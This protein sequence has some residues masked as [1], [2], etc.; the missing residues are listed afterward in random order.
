M[1]F[2]KHKRTRK[3]TQHPAIDDF[4]KRVDE[5]AEYLKSVDDVIKE[6]NEA[7]CEPEID[8]KISGCKCSIM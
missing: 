4:N 1:P 5:V 6:I 2:F 8:I 3:V 7:K